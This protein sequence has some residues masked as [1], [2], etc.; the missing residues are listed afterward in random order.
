MYTPQPVPLELLAFIR[1]GTKFLVAGHKEP[2]GD[3]VGSQLAL[4]SALHRLGKEAF[5]CSAGPF[6][7]TEIMPYADRFIREAGAKER[8]GARVVVLDCSCADRTGDLHASL[9]GLP[10]AIID[11]HVTNENTRSTTENPVFLD[12]GAPATCFMI[13]GL[14]EALNLPLTPEEAELLFFGLCT[15]TGFFRHADTNGAAVFVAASRL[16]AAGASPK[17]AYQAINGGKSLNSRL[18]LGR[19][20][21]RAA[22]CFEGKLILSEETYE[23]TQRF[24]LEGRD[25]DNLY[26][27]LQSVSGVEAITIIRQETP[28]N[29]TVGFRSRDQV[30]V[31]E[32]A[33]QFGGG[34]HKNAA[35]AII[36][37]TIEELRPKIIY[38][39]EKVFRG[40]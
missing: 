9:E 11:H 10:T 14:L 5:P 28:E 17:R 34:G 6:K 30:N 12:A 26:Q 32:I 15:D 22:P 24:G 39:F 36:P 33:R 25:S 31:A 2:D 21:S 13:L 8:E 18:L 4:T 35:G 1:E 20:L 38:A 7:R 3:C 40:S 19:V 37:G 27:L 23:E 29:C 16:A